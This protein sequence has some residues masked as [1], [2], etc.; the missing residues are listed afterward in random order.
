MPSST[1][2]KVRE[3]R[4][5]RIAARRGLRLEKARRRDRLA[6]DYGRWSLV[7]RETGGEVFAGSDLAAVEAFLGRKLPRG[8]AYDSAPGIEIHGRA[9]DDRYEVWRVDSQGRR[10]WVVVDTLDEAVDLA[11]EW[12]EED[13]SPSGE[14][15]E[16]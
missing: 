7:R 3:N 5:R 11:H 14:D 8:Q 6:P 12:L 13:S 15:D 10:Q 2:E 4:L 1:P 16:R 9:D